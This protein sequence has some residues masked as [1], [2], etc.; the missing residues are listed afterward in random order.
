MHK[1]QRDP[2]PP[3]CL[4]RYR[5]GIDKWEMGS[6]TPTERGEIWEK[7]NAMQ[8]N[9]CAYCEAAIDAENRH[10]EHFRQRSKHPQ[11]TFNWSNLFG[12]CDRQDTCGKHKDACGPYQH[13]DLIK[14]DIDDPDDFLAFTPNGSVNPRV[15]LSV[16]DHKRATESIRIFNLNGALRQIRFSEVIG[17]VQTAETFAAMAIHFDSSEWLPMLEEELT[18][19]A[20][21]PFSTAIRH[22]LTRQS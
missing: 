5:H 17:Y 19:T 18:T 11:G 20:L 10:I 14:P 1:L 2:N 22:V 7:L 8:S 16:E 9:R 6:P 15:N 3:A 13:T 12:S 4:K 21:L